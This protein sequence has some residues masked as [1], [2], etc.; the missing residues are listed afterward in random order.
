MNLRLFLSICLV[1]IIFLLSCSKDNKDIVK[2]TVV[3]SSPGHLFQ[4]NGLDTIQVLATIS[5]D[6]NIE[7]VTVSLR[8]ENDIDVLSSVSKRPNTKN[9]E[10]NIL[11]FFDNLHLSAGEYHMSVRAFDGENTTT[12]YVS[13]YYNEVPRFR[14]GVFFVTNTQTSSSIY[15]LDSTY[16]LSVNS[17]ILINGDYLNAEIN[18]V[19]QQLI[20]V[21][22]KNGGVSGSD[23]TTGTNFWN[24][25]FSS[26]SAP[27]YTGSYYN[28][29]IIFLGRRN[30][31]I[32]AFD[33][34][35]NPYFFQTSPHMG[36]DVESMTLH[37]NQYLISEE[38]PTSSGLGQLV[39]Y[40]LAGT[41]DQS[42]AL[43]SDVIGLFSL[44]MN[45]VVLLANDGASNG[46]VY[47]YKTTDGSINSFFLNFNL[48]QIDDCIE[49]G[50]G[51]Y[52][53][54][55]G[56]NLTMIN[57]NTAV[58]S[59]IPTNTNVKRI[60]LDKVNNE[61]FLGNGTE[62]DVYDFGSYNYKDSYTHSEEIKDVLFWYN[63]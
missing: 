22:N 9:Y 60:W 55:Q 52:L 16:N 6:K 32:H 23:L 47:L 26:S 63:R 10:L 53:V 29:Q 48:A 15:S 25:P 49:I 54:A 7:S 1:F 35:G 58:K 38:Q 46:Q 18:S 40:T 28:N 19:D 33:K 31:G 59:T 5:D 14:R 2:P 12:K 36:Y 13:I 51:V 61:L 62:L 11:Y 17:P 43:T 45:T 3:I 37:N 44:D 39:Q 57:I 30:L 42:S 41:V 24:I 21:S 4:V 8:D 20:Y 56:G 34:N 50:V 27:Y